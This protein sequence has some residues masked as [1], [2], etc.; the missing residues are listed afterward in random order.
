MPFTFCHPAAVLPFGLIRSRYI[1][2]SGLVIG[3]IIPDFEYF[4]R[5][6]V[7]STV[8]HSFAGVFL[9]DLPL[10][11][12]LYFVF[13][14]VVREPFIS[15]LPG[16]LKKRLSGFEGPAWS[17]SLKLR[18]LVVSASILFGVLTHL[19]WD[20]FTHKGGYFVVRSE[21]LQKDFG[22]FGYVVPAYKYA[23]HFSSLFGAIAI[24]GVVYRM[25]VRCKETSNP[26]KRFWLWAGAVGV[27]LL[28]LNLAVN[29]SLNIG[30]IVVSGISGMLLGIFI[31]SVKFPTERNGR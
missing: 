25:P 8:S 7:L 28:L 19:I 1:S 2:L 18:L 10:G 20:G 3:S 9:F 6:K 31:A 12:L 24:I 4:L 27:C 26:E 13:H 17:G 11:L 29:S 14:A 15:N 22:F 30:D 16:F 23:Q 21:F 5:L